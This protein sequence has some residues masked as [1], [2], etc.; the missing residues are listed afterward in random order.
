[1][2]GTAWRLVA[3]TEE[4]LERIADW[5][6]TFAQVIDARNHRVPN[7]LPQVDW[8]AQ[9]VRGGQRVETVARLQRMPDW[10]PA[11][12]ERRAYR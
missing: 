11:A 1:M 6:L 8:N 9:L 12:D 5:M 10:P 3:S 4:R 2:D 7:T